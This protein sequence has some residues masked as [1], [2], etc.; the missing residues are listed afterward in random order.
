MLV[1][2]SAGLPYVAGAS[3]HVATTVAP[4]TDMVQ[5]VG[6]ALLHVHGLVPEGVNS[7]TFQPAPGDVQ[8]LAQADLVVLNGLQLEIPIEKLVYSSGKPGVTVVKLGE[9]TVSQAEW[10]F[11]ASFPKAQGLPNPH[12]WLNVD[13]AMHYVTLIRDH[14]SALDRDHAAVYAAER[15]PGPVDRDGVRTV[16]VR[17]VEQRRTGL[18]HRH[19]ITAIWVT[20]M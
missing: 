10:V 17:L 6:G 14:V 2:T 1:L 9:H 8:Y 19:W 5:Q 12:L 7:H 13:Y 20:A 4:L 18:R 11:D 3:L 15:P 16:G